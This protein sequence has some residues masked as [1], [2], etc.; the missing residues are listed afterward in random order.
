MM[1]TVHLR[2]T[3]LQTG[4]SAGLQSES[5]DRLNVRVAHWITQLCT[6]CTCFK[7][8]KK[9]SHALSP[10]TRPRQ[11][12]STLTLTPS[13]QHSQPDSKTACDSGA[14]SVLLNASKTSEQKMDV[15]QPNAEAEL[16]FA[17]L[18]AVHLAG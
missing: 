5:C 4:I 18:T 13:A 9:I 15:T 16:G 12:D 11:T 3:D 1:M 2:Q 17:N 8:N 6:S 10:C 14:E 7:N